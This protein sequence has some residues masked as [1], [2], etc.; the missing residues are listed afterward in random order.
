MQLPRGAKQGLATGA[1]GLVVLVGFFIWSL[2]AYR[3]VHQPLSLV[4]GR[5][6]QDFKVNVNADYIIGIEVERKLPNETID[7]LLGV[8]YFEP[9]GTCANTPSVLDV[10]W[11][12][13]SDGVPINT[14][15]YA[16]MPLGAWSNSTIEAEL[17]SFKGQRGRRYALEFDIAQD[18]RQLTITNPM[19]VVHVDDWD[20]EDIVFSRS[21]A[22][23]AFAVCAII[24][25]LKKYS[26]AM[27][28][29]A[30][31]HH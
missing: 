14:M 3:S 22:A 6:R 13:T 2:V 5:V 29:P 16:K 18:G 9:K 1:L 8:D 7:C 21:I 26:L 28:V 17:A 15:S 20:Y 19:L 23:V 24:V 11:K 27:K 4:P 12:L 30:T 10:S 25:G 31:T